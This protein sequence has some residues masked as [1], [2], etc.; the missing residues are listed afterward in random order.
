MIEKYVRNI[1]KWQ[2]PNSVNISIALLGIIS[3]TAIMFVAFPPYHL[4]SFVI[5]GFI[6]VFWLVA[7]GLANYPPA[8]KAVARDEAEDERYSRLPYQV[9]AMYQTYINL[10]SDLRD[11]LNDYTIEDLEGLSEGTASDIN[12]A[13][14]TLKKQY[15]DQ[16]VLLQKP[17]HDQMLSNVKDLAESYRRSNETLQLGP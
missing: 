7:L 3:F 5:M 17:R 11:Q 2:D 6:A 12:R 16:Q 8:V 10:P 15:D 1:R 4:A 13:L 9:R 14:Q